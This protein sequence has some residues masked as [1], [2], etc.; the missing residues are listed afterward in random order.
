MRSFDSGKP[1]R[2]TTG[3]FNENDPDFSPD[4]RL[5]AYRSERDGG[6]IYVQPTTTGAAP[7]LVAKSG[8]KPRFSPDGKWIAFFRLSGS[9]D[10]NVSAGM[11]QLFIVPPEGGESR[12]IQPN[13]AYAR[14][15]IWAPDGRHILFA[16][17]L[18]DKRLVGEP[19]RR[20]GSHA[21]SCARIDERFFV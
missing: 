7:K 16:G 1:Q 12:Q 10:V 6:R 18:P 14:N 2:L 5:I 17:A 3:E 15:P 8:W 9:E 20:R 11:G 4:A 13:F 21:H 19:T